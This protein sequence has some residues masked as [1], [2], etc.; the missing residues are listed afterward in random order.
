MTR[1]LR[2]LVLVSVV[3]AVTLVLPGCP[4]RP[5]KPTALIALGSHLPL[6][7][8]APDGG[9]V[10]GGPVD[11]PTQPVVDLA[12]AGPTASPAAVRAGVPLLLN[13]GCSTDPQQWRLSYRW[14]LALAPPGSL[15]ALGEPTGATPG[16]VPDLPGTYR[17]RLVV[18]NG[19]LTSDAELVIEASACGQ[20]SPVVT[21]VVHDP[22]TPQTGELVGLRAEV[23]DHDLDVGCGLHQT[24]TW[25][26]TLVGQPAGS[27][28]LLHA[29]T[30]ATP[31]LVPDRDG[32]Y[33]VRLVATD[34][35]GRASIA[36]LH[37]I[38]VGPCGARPPTLS[39]L[40]ATP[41]S[42]GIGET[43]L[44]AATVEDPD[45]ACNP[46]E[47][48]H[49][50]WSFTSLPRGST[51]HL[52]DVAVKAPSFQ[53]ELPGDYVV[54]LVVSD[55]AGHLS[56]ARTLTVT[57]QPCGGARP[58]VQAVTFTPAGP[59]IG[60]LVQASAQVTDDDTAAPCGRVESFEY[61]WTLV[62]QPSGSSAR[63]NNEVAREPSFLA[64]LAGT[65]A[66]R[67]VATD[68][69]RH[70]SVA[71]EASVT[72]AACGGAVPFVSVAASAGST[73]SPRTGQGV[74]VE[75]QVTDADTDVGCAAHAAVY[76]Y[77][78]HFEEVPLGSHTT[79]N[80]RSARNPSFMADVPGNYVLV[81]TATDPTGR[82]GRSAPYTVIASIC[83]S[84]AP[85]VTAAATPS[86]PGI[87]TPTALTATPSDADTQAG[88]EAHA[89]TFTYA[90]QLLDQPAGSTARL[91]DARA[92]APSFTPDLPGDYVAVV[93]VTDPTGRTGQSTPLNVSVSACGGGVP[94]PTAAV[95]SG[96]SASP[97]TGRV[98][99]LDASAT[100]A[101]LL[102][103]C[104]AHPAVFAWHWSFL[105]LPSGAQARLNDPSARN[106]SFTPDV[107][108]D[109]VLQVSATDPTGRTGRSAPLTITA[110]A[111]GTNAPV[112]SIAAL[113]A[114][115]RP[116]VGIALDGRGSSDADNDPSGC[117][118]NQALALRWRLTEVPAGSQT[119]VNAPT[120]RLAGFTPDVAG[121]YTVELVVTDSTGR[122]SA[123]ASASVQVG[124][125][126]T[127]APAVGTL[128]ANP[129]G[130]VAVGQRVQF[131]AAPTDA[132]I[133]G[134][135]NAHGPLTTFAWFFVLVPAGSRAAL[136]Q[137]TTLQPWF[138]PDQSGTYQL[139][140]M[141]TDPTGRTATS[142]LLTVTVNSCGLNLPSSTPLA[143]STGVPAS[144][145]ISVNS[146][147]V[148][149]LDSG[150]VTDADNST[151]GVVPPQTFAFHW[152]LLEV[153][154]GSQARLVDPT[155]A[156]P[157]FTADLQG[158]YRAELVVT[159]SAGVAG[160]P[161]TVTVTAGAVLA[162][163]L[164]PPVAVATLSW[165]DLNNIL[166]TRPCD[167]ASAV[168]IQAS[169]TWQGRQQGAPQWLP[170]TV[171]LDGLGSYD[172]DNSLSC[173]AGQ[174]LA[175]EW[176]LLKLPFNR[177]GGSGT[178]FNN[179]GGGGGGGG[180]SVFTRTATPSF[181]PDMI[182][183]Y[184][185]QLVVNDSTARSSQPL[186][187][188][189][190]VQ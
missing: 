73:A 83:G 176:T 107:P 75:A 145:P 171:F 67:L 157:W 122:T 55:A 76:V 95:A 118:L 134:T 180:G 40:Q 10:D 153:P 94:Q 128:T 51:A 168:T 70:Q 17:I 47:E 25:A 174:T 59:G 156:K 85:T 127:N 81:A 108:G 160:T 4:A 137:A 102:P 113:P 78:W 34:S 92:H 184:W 7:A 80:D 61:R 138:T 90:W 71:K 60:Q 120:A 104:L 15:A 14:Q 101:D 46:A 97:A 162:C 8:G 43:V 117:A 183:T 130:T 69:E 86:A 28:T 152:R 148:V 131:A 125:C 135:C 87:G 48:L 19:L 179:G 57:V 98:T 173:A 109:Y 110:G 45:L 56:T 182:G 147:A 150:A 11:D 158:I 52:N 103:D 141:V 133:G 106:P 63:L 26:W 49:Y 140:F 3:L 39:E 91:N 161:T 163:G 151:C 30:G 185:A 144:N 33:V 24:L 50:A 6:P 84:A 169:Q 53:P 164:N 124:T 126:G 129:A 21:S 93:T 190:N 77:A 167:N 166:V 155:L 72:V 186:L 68:A 1:A 12:C 170:F 82:T 16:F 18:S 38:D 177:G 96:S 27:L 132:D 54:R 165:V 13:G 187:C 111:C 116:G 189:I 149:L 123:P 31:S 37:T 74:Q 121:T 154:A 5:Q 105:A 178:S 114:S 181:D 20:Q 66:L 64:D 2:H 139:R 136:Q 44:L 159:D 9:F 41:P 65:Y 62:G 32:A 112:A 79:L 143:S 146:G 89:A 58:V 35:T 188:K 99:Q 142:D 100:D 88:C 22:A 175:Y 42:P 172:P 115:S 23:V 119:T 36:R 29:G